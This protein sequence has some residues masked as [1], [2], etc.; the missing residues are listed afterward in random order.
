MKKSIKVIALIGLLVGLA[1]PTSAMA[2]DKPTVV[3][4]TMTPDTVDTVSSNALVSFDLTVSNSTGIASTQ[5]QLTLTDGANNT[6]MTT[7]V[8]TDS[9]VKNSLATVVFHGSLAIPA[10]LP[11]GVYSASA[12]PVSSL[13]ADGSVGYPTGTLYATSTSKVVGAED[14][15][16]VRTN[17]V[18][19]YNYPTFAGPAFDKTVTQTFL[20]SKFTTV[21]DPIWKVGES[22]DLANYYE[23]QVPGITLKLTV[24]TPSICSSNALVLQL[25]AI[26]ACAFTI[27]TAKNLDYQA[28]KSDQVISVTAARTK[29]TYTVGVIATQSSSALP[30]SIPG[31]FVYGPLGLVIP[32]SATPSVCYV[33]GTYINVISGGTCTINYSSP[34]TTTYLASD[35]F[36]LTFQITRSAQTV[37]FSAPAN[38]TL[39]SKTLALSATSSTGAPVTFQSDSPTICSVIGNSLNFLTAGNCQVEAIQVGSATVSPASVTQSIAVTGSLPSSKASKVKTIICMKSGKSKTFAGS[40][41]PAGFKARK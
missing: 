34:A 37:S 36:P 14:S 10:T 22:V 40:K 29:P 6:L 18:L 12:K 5:T 17:G 31:P 27:S 24:A 3:S 9:P 2:A 19:N 13:N 21:A 38:A 25:S 8:R 11:S 30:L 26:G 41:C 7:L 39:A 23:V 4:F 33:T 35:V 28:Q 20:N 1:E 15:L 16:L 32:K